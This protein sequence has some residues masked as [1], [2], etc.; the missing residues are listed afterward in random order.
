[1]LTKEKLNKSI[2]NLPDSFTIY[3]LMKIEN[4]ETT[5]LGYPITQILEAAG[6]SSA[7]YYRKKP[8]GKE[9]TRSGPKSGIS[10]EVLLAEIR[11]EIK[12]SIFVDEGYKKIWKK[13]FTL[14]D[15]FTCP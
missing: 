11:T 6:L 7:A 15:A 12:E 2:T 5:K 8:V 10:D 9:K 13:I 14:K 4:S 3:E 1:M